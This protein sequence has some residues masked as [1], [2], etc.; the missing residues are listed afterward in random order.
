MTHLRPFLLILPLLAST[1]CTPEIGEADNEASEAD[2]VCGDGKIDPGESCDDGNVNSGDGCD[3]LCKTEAAPAPDPDSDPDPDPDPEPDPDPDPEAD[4]EPVC[5]DGLLQDA[6]ECDDGNLDP[7]DGC[8]ETCLVDSAFCEPLYPASCNTTDVWNTTGIGSTD[9]VDT[10]SCTEFDESGREYT[11][12]F[13]PEADTTMTITLTPAEGL[14]LDLFILGDDGNSLCEGG[15]CALYADETVDV[16]FPA[17]GEYWIV[18]DG[19][20]GAEGDYSIEFSCPEEPTLECPQGEGNN[21]ESCED[22]YQGEDIWR[23][24]I[25]PVLDGATVSQVC[26]DIGN[27]A[28]WHTF[29][30]NPT[31]C[32]ACDG[33]FDVGCCAANSGSSGCPL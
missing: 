1:A 33:E 25:S 6:E 17:G 16:I 10:Y 11:Y 7:G 3:S 28:L 19:Y 8:S 4:P 13:A 14:D 31:E 5:G 15:D 32:C 21:G 9:N 22:V 30:I 18:V 12:Y 27:G 20:L 2:I 29:H 24:T 23:C 26:R